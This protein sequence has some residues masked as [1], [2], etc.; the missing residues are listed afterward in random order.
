MPDASY[1]I[2]FAITSH[3]LGHLTR[4]LAIMREF[5]AA[6]PH[7]QAIVSTGISRERIAVDLPEPFLYRQIRYEPG[8]AQ[9]N[10]FEVDVHRTREAYRTFFRMRKQ[11]LREEEDFIKE[12]KCQAVVSDI[13]ALPVRAAAN[14]GVPAVG[15]SNFTWDW[16]LEPILKGTQLECIVEQLAEDYSFGQL[17]LRLPFSPSISPFS[18][19]EEVPLISRTARLS[20]V[21]VRQ[22]L[23]VPLNDLRSLVVVCPGGWEAESWDSVHVEGCQDIRFIMVGD[24]QITADAPTIHLPHD[25]P[26]GLIFPDLVQTA[27]V[28]L[29]KPGYGIVSEC[30]LHRIPMVL[31]ERPDFRET[32][33]MLQ[34]MEEIGPHSRISLNDFFSGRWEE[35]ILQALTSTVSW[36][37]FESDG[38]RKVALRLGSFFQI[39]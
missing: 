15:F 9:K 32:P 39:S 26:Y 25:L 37:T 19:S 4:T 31:T 17:H 11:K 20:P 36:K 12:F 7:I 38:A 14:V 8:T 6:Y 33:V 29:A 28:V 21:E 34:W 27:D 5:I 3:G 2:L 24:L 18:Y 23:G 1:R 10:C 30:V 35:P 13:P 16:I 22:R